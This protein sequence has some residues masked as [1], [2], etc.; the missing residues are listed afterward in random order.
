MVSDCMLD[1]QRHT[2]QTL[3]PGL[4]VVAPLQEVGNGHIAGGL[5]QLID[6]FSNDVVVSYMS[7]AHSHSM[8]V[9]P[10]AFALTGPM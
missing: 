1:A 4:P 7:Y 2:G 3:T 10:T 5:T 6:I 8:D 9:I